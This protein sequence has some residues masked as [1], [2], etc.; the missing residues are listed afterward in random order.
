M[1]Y[2]FVL[3]LITMSAVSFAQDLRSGGVLKPVQ[4][5]MDI[6]RYKLV[7][8]V[9]P[10]QRTFDGWVEIDLNLLNPS[11]DLLLDLWDSLQVKEIW[12]NGKSASYDHN[13]DLI[14]ITNSQPWP[15]GKT[16]L[17][18]AYEG[19]PG[20]ATRPPWTGGVQ[21]A[22]DDKGNPWIALTCQG[23]GAKIF[24]SL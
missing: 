2:L 17:K 18:V 11:A 6:R 8:D 5:N 19:R 3:L 7:L 16:K 24:F 21:W 15:A 12:V 10:D 9:D 23:E 4:A 13:D 20:V 22:K 1:R 14:K